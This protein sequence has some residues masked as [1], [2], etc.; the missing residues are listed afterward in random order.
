MFILKNV[1]T[2]MNF[3]LSVLDF[4]NKKCMKNIKTEIKA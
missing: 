2:S 3:K 4:K 1:F